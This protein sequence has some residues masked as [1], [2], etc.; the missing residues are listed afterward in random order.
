MKD[1]TNVKAHKHEKKNDR[2]ENDSLQAGLAPVFQRMMGSN[3]PRL[4]ELAFSRTRVLMMA[5]TLMAKATNAAAITTVVAL[6][7][8]RSRSSSREAV[9]R[10]Q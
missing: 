2:D 8:P 7:S 10:I 1:C 4:R 3:H 9:Y 6:T 5:P